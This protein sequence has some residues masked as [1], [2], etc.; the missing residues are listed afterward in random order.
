MSFVKRRGQAPAR[1]PEPSALGKQ[2]HSF[3]GSGIRGFKVNTSPLILIMG[4]SGSGKSTIGKMLADRLAGAFLEA[5]EFHPTANIDKMSRGKP[6]SDEDR[7]P[8]L[9]AVAC[10][11]RNHA[12]PFPLVLACSALK[13][14]YRSQLQLGESPVIFL[15]GPRDTIEHRLATRLGHFM[16]RQLLD[17]QLEDLEE[18]NDAITISIASSPDKIVDQ[19]AREINRRLD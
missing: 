10:A 1:R 8:W 11:V 9:D 6:L 19:I 13:H 16:P 18:P 5:D 3:T 12:G 2:G 14:S 7:R 15:T 4:V 17:S